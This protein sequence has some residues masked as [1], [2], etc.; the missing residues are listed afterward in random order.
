MRGQALEALTGQHAGFHQQDDTVAATGDVA[1]F[2]CYAPL[3]RENPCRW[4]SPLVGCQSA[5]DWPGYAPGAGTR[6]QGLTERGMLALAN[7]AGAG[8]RLRGAPTGCPKPESRPAS[9]PH[10]TSR[11]T[12]MKLITFLLY[13]RV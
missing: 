12:V 2:A 13:L 1:H 4:S 8:G 11:E 9:P 7:A 6:T 5:S 3:G 10:P